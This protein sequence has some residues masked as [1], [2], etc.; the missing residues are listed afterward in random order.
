MI[1]VTQG[2]EKGIGL[3]IFLKSFLLLSTQEKSQIVLVA[4][5]KV[6][7]QNLTDLKLS[8]SSFK[9][10]LLA[11]PVAEPSLPSSTRTLLHALNIITKDDILVTLPTSKDQLVYNGKNMAVILSFS[12]VITIM[13]TS[14]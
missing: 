3:E 5:S 12:E 7:D 14:Q 2:R 8:K 10:L 6:L 4:D 1:Y 9:D 13:P 11:T